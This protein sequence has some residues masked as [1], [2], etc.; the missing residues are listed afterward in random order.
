MENCLV[1]YDL[2]CIDG[3]K[4]FLLIKTKS[5]QKRQWD[6]KSEHL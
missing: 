4:V 3:G 2:D 6:L 5:D 1:H